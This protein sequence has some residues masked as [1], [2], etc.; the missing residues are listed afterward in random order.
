MI[1][2]RIAHA[3]PWP[4]EVAD[5]KFLITGFLVVLAD[6]AG[7][8]AVPAWLM[9]GEHAGADSLPRLLDPPGGVTVTAGLPEELG[10]RLLRAAGATVTGVEIEMAGDG[11]AGPA[12]D[13]GLTAGA[14]TARIKLGTPAG[15]RQVTARL[16]LGLAVAAAAGAPLR[17]ADAVMDRFAVP[18]NGDDVLR[19]V[20]DRVPPG[21]LWAE[22]RALPRLG[23]PAGATGRPRF[24]PRN[25]AFADGLDRWE[26]DLGPHSGAGSPQDAG[27]TA[28]VEGGSA[29]LSAAVPRP[30][31]SA[32]LVQT[33]FADDYR[34]ATVVFRGEISAGDV[35]QRAGLRLDIVT[36]ARRVEVD[37]GPRGWRVRPGRAGQQRPQRAPL[38]RPEREEHS[39]TVS[40]S[41]GWTRHEVTALVPDDADL[42]R[43]G[44]TLTGPG[45]VALR[46]PGLVRGA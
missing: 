3:L 31:G 1:T 18:A 37:R 2:V 14:V 26:L 27:Y 9:H 38:R 42:I 19:P 10:T 45:L 11:T 23:R 40:G 7:H 25:L 20:L 12:P 4:G 6:D 39:S 24:E 16:G 43:F 34:G 22:H 32:A 15:S 17:V 29:V 41:S 5:G 28:A 30:A 36:R 8:R 35:A 13:A 33:I 21:Q 46:S 44:I